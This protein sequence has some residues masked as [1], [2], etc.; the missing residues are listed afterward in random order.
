MSLQDEKGQFPTENIKVCV[1]CDV[2]QTDWC[3]QA[4]RDFGLLGLTVPKE[5]GALLC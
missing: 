1:L 5:N 2:S 3:V 4:L